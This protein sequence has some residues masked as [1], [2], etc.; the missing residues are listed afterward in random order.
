MGDGGEQGF[1][2]VFDVEP[3]ADVFACA[4][5]RDVFAAERLEDDYRDEFFGKLEGAVLAE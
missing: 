4:I 1:G 2:V 3:V 5:D